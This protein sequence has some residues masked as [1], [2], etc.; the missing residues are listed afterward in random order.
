MGYTVQPAM[1]PSV[2]DG[3]SRLLPGSRPTGSGLLN[4]N[5]RACMT[6]PGA[7]AAPQLIEQKLSHTET[8]QQ[9]FQ[10]LGQSGY[11]V[12]YSA[13]RPRCAQTC[14]SECLRCCTCTSWSCWAG[15]VRR[16]TTTKCLVWSCGKVHVHAC[17]RQLARQRPGWSAGLQVMSEHECTAACSG[18]AMKGSYGSIVV[19]ACPRA[20]TS[21]R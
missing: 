11:F 13:D 4:P 20:G 9:A 2:G 6:L 14:R 17:S 8:V 21:T 18:A 5:C 15:C 7:D 3:Q 19:M 12:D 16:W 10:A 1:M